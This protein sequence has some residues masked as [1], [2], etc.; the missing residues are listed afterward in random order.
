ME[1]RTSGG[2]TRIV[3]ACGLNW[4]LAEATLGHFLHWLPVPGLAGAI[5][6]PVGLFF[7]SRALWAAEAAR[8]AAAPGR[9]GFSLPARIPAVPFLVSAVAA[10][11]KMID[12][13]LPGRGLIMGLRPALAILTEGLLFSASLAAF[14][15][16]F[17]RRA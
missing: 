10:A 8:P 9:S 3:L 2:S 17:R 6:L 14:P 13:L 1:R 5:M 7:M 11:I 4:G 15:A 12:V 16:L